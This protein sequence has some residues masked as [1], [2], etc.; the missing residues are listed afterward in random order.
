MPWRLIGWAGAAIVLFL[1]ALGRVGSL[2]VDWAS[3]STVGYVEVFWTV[4]ATKAM[5]FAAT[6]AVSVLLLWVNAVLAL[7][8]ASPRRTRLPRSS[9]KSSPYR[10][11]RRGGNRVVA[12]GCSR[13]A[14]ACNDHRRRPRPRIF[15]RDRRDH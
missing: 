2:V 10:T 11:A 8:F 1:V 6:F 3:F 13:V 7:R 14:V 4:F 15:G 9:T 5:I 12:A